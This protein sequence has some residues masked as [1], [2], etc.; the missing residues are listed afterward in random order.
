MVFSDQLLPPARGQE[1]RER[2]AEFR[3][4]VL[5]SETEG[6][7][8]VCARM[9]VLMSISRRFDTYIRRDALSMRSCWRSNTESVVL[10][11]KYTSTIVFFL[12]KPLNSFQAL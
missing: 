12:I 3:G 6:V 5:V 8:F 4:K 9:Y 10:L 11:L 7:Y 2:V 1:F